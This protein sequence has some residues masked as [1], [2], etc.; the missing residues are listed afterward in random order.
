METNIFWSLKFLN[1]YLS[2]MKEIERKFLVNEKLDSALQGVEG[3]AIK[4][5][6]ISDKDGI[7]VRVRTKGTKGFLTIKGKSE[8]ISRTEFEYEI[9]YPEA[10]AL[11]RDF[12]KR[13]LSKIRYEIRSGKHTWEVDVFKDK[14]EGLIVAEIELSDENEAFDLPEWVGEEVSDDP[15]YYNSNLIKTITG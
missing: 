13:V 14:L 12:C 2:R 10:E 8:G 3:K 7:T 1:S 4:Q 15:R 5:G 6:Y 11:L 9:P